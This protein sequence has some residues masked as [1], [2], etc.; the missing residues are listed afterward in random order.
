MSCYIGSPG[1]CDIFRTFFRNCR[2]LLVDITFFFRSSRRN[3]QV[4]GLIPLANTAENAKSVARQCSLDE[5]LLVVKCAMEVVIVSLFSPILQA[6]MVLSLEVLDVKCDTNKCQPFAMLQCPT[7]LGVH[8]AGLST[9]R[10]GL[11]S[12]AYNL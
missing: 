10:R 6:I 1:A 8:T 12:N 7:V 2:Q 4:F 3:Y 11:V 9:T 5:N